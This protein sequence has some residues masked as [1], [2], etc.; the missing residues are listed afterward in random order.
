ME[1]SVAHIMLV[2]SFD[3]DSCKNF[4][5]THRLVNIYFRRMKVH[6][7]NNWI[8]KLGYKYNNYAGRLSFIQDIC[9]QLTKAGRHNTKS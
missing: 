3:D 5:T 1:L 9:D 6:G 8:D 7:E 2:R 4:T